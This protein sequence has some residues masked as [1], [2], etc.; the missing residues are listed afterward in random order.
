MEKIFIILSIV[1][2]FAGLVFCIIYTRIF[3]KAIKKQ[4]LIK[5]ANCQNADSAVV[6]SSQIFT[7]SQTAFY[8]P[9]KQHSHRGLKHVTPAYQHNFQMYELNGCY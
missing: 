1:F 5:T 8:V 4:R 7:V 2:A 6:Y 3:R 9:R